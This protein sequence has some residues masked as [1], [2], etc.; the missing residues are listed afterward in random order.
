M[1]MG[2]DDA[3]KEYGKVMGGKAASLLSDWLEREE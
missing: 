3:A 1:V 2:F